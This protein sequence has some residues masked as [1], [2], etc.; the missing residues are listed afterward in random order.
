MRIQVRTYA[1]LAEVLGP[2]SEVS[3]EEDHGIRAVLGVIAGNEE[4]RIR[5][6]FDEDGEVHDYLIIVHNRVRVEHCDLSSVTLCEGDE[7]AILPP[8]AGG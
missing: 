2:E 5:A 4:V 1:R 7:I 6:L 3:V 8:L